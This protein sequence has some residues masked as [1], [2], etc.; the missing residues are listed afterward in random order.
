MDEDNPPMVLPNGMVYS[1]KVK[2]K[3]KNENWFGS[4]E[5]KKRNKKSRLE[6][7]KGAKGY[8][9]EVVDGKL[10]IYF[11]STVCVCVCVVL[12]KIFEK[13]NIR[14]CCPAMIQ[15]TLCALERNR[16]LL[17]D[18]VGKRIF[19]DKKKRKNK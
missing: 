4:M 9:S 5:K 15:L 13:F 10:F 1:R 8:R 12:W 18:N 6:G 17:T 19:W 11:F 7:G 16:R 3:K 2:K 14:R